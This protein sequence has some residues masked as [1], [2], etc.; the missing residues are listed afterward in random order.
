MEDEHGVRSECVEDGSC[1]V[2][3]G[4][5]QL[6]RAQELRGHRVDRKSVRVM[7]R[8]FF[9]TENERE[10]DVHN[11]AVVSDENVARMPVRDAEDI[12]DR[13]PRA[14]CE[15]KSFSSSGRLEP[16]LVVHERLEVALVR[17]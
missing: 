3:E 8:V 15:N 16:A 4:V 7:A 11:S 14:G 13:A 9:L 17:N 6:L 5:L 12:V 10:I 2:D 1:V